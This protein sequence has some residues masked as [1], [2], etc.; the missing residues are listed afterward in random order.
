METLLKKSNPKRDQW[1]GKVIWFLLVTEA[2]FVLN[3]EGV[4]ARKETQDF[5][6]LVHC[7]QN[8]RREIIETCTSGLSNSWLHWAAKSVPES[9]FHTAWEES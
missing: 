4:K 7:Y 8:L 6:I 1:K 2:I 9:H 3:S 5:Q